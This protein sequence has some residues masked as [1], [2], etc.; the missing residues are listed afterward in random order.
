MQNDL[1]AVNETMPRRAGRSMAAAKERIFGLTREEIKRRI[2]LPW[3]D[4]FR[5]CAR[6]ILIR[7]GRALINAS[8]TFLSV[9]FLMFVATMITIARSVAKTQVGF[10]LT[11]EDIARYN[12]LV[13][14]AM[15]I[16][17]VGIVNSML[18]G[19]M[20]R[21]REIGTMKCLGAL[22]EFIIR[23]FLIEAGLMGFIGSAIGAVIGLLVAMLRASFGIGWHVWVNTQWAIYGEHGIGLIGWLIISVAAGTI[24]SILAGVPP[25]RYA[26]KLP[27]AAA[28]RTEI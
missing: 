1:M 19:V 6:N 15:L 23:L 20:E 27:A 9:A 11:P 4:A 3:R 2:K 14:M 17:F 13:S 25:A 16:C 21:Y 22:D 28:L 10:Q 12:W 8:T 26:A 18:M 7:F 24:L 5:I